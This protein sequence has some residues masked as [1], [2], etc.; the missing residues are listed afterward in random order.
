[1]NY[2]ALDL[3]SGLT[4][5][6]K[7]QARNSFGLSA[8]TDEV[9]GTLAVGFKPSQPEAPT[10]SNVADQV[11]VQWTAPN[12]NGSP[13]T[14]YRIELRQNDMT[15]FSQDMTN[16][17]GSGALITASTQCSIPLSV[18]T[19][20]PYSLVFGD[21]VFAKVVAYNYYGESAESDSANGAVI[22][23]VPDSPILLT[24][25][26]AVTTAYVIGF[27]WLDGVSTGG[28]PIIDY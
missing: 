17:D 20:A 19:A 15:T 27:S 1:M 24:E 26:S 9:Q 16:C 10:T 8:Y 6:F 21:S 4:Y 3:T 23:L 18:L 13:I 14:G 11:L 12:E 2:P 25:N 22:L 28:T 5:K 7:L